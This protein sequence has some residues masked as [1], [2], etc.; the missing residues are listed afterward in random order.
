MTHQKTDRLDGRR[1]VVTGAGRGTGAAITA[2]LR[3]AGATVLGV[4]RT[5]PP[6]AGLFLPADLTTDEGIAAVADGVREHLGAADILVHTLGGS[7][8]P[9]GGFAALTG[10]HWDDELRLNLLAAVRLDRALLPGMLETGSGAVVHVSS[11]QRRMPLYDGTLGYAAAKA[12][13]TAYSKGLANEVG[14]RG[15]RVNVV[16]PGFIR[17]SAADALIERMAATHGVTPGQ[18]LDRLMDSLGGIPLG[19]PAEPAEV[20]ELVAFLVSDRA[21]AITGAEHTIDGG[22]VPTVG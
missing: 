17:T 6:D 4:A 21:S 7:S 19:R 20:A 10:R 15:V 3:A 12:A 2:R 9:A 22:T 18:A 14:P 13:L 1:A 16:S 5:R 11:I 8:S